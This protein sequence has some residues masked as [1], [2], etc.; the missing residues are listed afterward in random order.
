VRSVLHQTSLL[1]GGVG[2]YSLENKKPR[3]QSPR[4]PLDRFVTAP[5]APQKL[6]SN[7][8]ETPALFASLKEPSSKD[9]MPAQEILI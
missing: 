9:C 4:Q 7:K 6:R 8:T 2:H 5:Q 3:S 1:W